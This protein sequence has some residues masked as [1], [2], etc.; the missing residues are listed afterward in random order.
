MTPRARTLFSIHLSAALV[1]IGPTLASAAE[2]RNAPETV[3]P[4][5]SPSPVKSP[6]ATSVSLDPNKASRF[7]R[8]ATGDSFPPYV[9]RALPGLQVAPDGHTH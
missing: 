1:L 5:V 8:V 4:K 9:S 3:I 7:P 2:R 6:T